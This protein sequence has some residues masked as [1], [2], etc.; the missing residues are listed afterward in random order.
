[1]LFTKI[2]WEKLDDDLK[3]WISMILYLLNHN[4]RKIFFHSFISHP[5]QV[6]TFIYRSNSASISLCN[7]FD[8]PAQI[9]RSMIINFAPSFCE[10]TCSL[11][12]KHNEMPIDSWRTNWTRQEYEKLS[13]FFPYWPYNFVL[14]LPIWLLIKKLMLLVLFEKLS[15]IACSSIDN[16]IPS[17]SASTT[18]QQ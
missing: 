3:H 7:T 13:M 16:S 10:I 6:I 5:I 15:F 17:M 4:I 12:P 1:M 2:V 14:Y 11:F 18:Y 8:D 9:T